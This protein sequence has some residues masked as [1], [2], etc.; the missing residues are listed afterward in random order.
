[1]GEY[2]L[3]T[4][5]YYKGDDPIPRL[6]TTLVVGALSFMLLFALVAVIQ[7][8]KAQFVFAEWDF[9]DEYGQGIDLFTI[10]GNSTGSWVQVGGN[11]HYYEPSS[12][13]WYTNASIKLVCF[14][15][16]NTTHVGAISEPDGKNYI[17]HNVT[18]FSAGVLIFSQQNFTYVTVQDI[19]APM[20]RYVYSVILNFVPVS[21]MIYTV[22]VTYE[23]F[24]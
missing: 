11:W 1:M 20:L 21:G 3:C 9:P 22:T 23:V 12:L 16:L 13:D 15:H 14:A 19:G 18:V 7:P 8:A 6:E 10:Y 5:V 17:Q 2:Y 4:V 24:Y